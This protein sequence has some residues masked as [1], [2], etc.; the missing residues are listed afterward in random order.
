[1]STLAKDTT[2]TAV[3]ATAAATVNTKEF[4]KELEWA[5]RFAEKKSTI[6][7]LYNVALRC[8]GGSL[9][10]TATDLETAGETSIPADGEFNVTVPAALALKY[11]KKISEPEIT[12]SV[13]G[14]NLVIKHGEDCGASINGLSLESFPELPTMPADMAVLSG[15]ETAL[16][17]AIMAIS[18]LDSRFTMNGALL[19][20][21]TKTGSRF[22][23]TD[24]HRLSLVGISADAAKP[25]RGVVPKFA[26][27][28]LA[29]L[30]EDT[31]LFA[32]D[33]NHVFFSNGNR[34]IL[35]RK[36]SGNFPDYERVV[37]RA[38]AACAT[39]D[40]EALRRHGDRV[41]LFAD[42]R[43]HCMLFHLADN[44]L[45]ISAEVVDMGKSR[46]SVATTWERPEWSSGFNWEFVA[47]FLNLVPKT[48][49]DLRFNL[50]PAG[51]QNRTAVVFAVEG[52]QYVLMPMRT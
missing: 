41:A 21:G 14:E 32:S 26:L 39:I 27:S 38:M 6:P 8:D 49:F 42:S 37:P 20:I 30:G 22:V 5:A 43:S 7:I 47:E 1:M 24:G 34:T 17:R 46:A 50:H 23:S 19:E 52:W 25:F 15:L 18:A 28:E 11:L 33:E 36:L 45:T 35:S 51:E 4:T 12:L 9:R 10:L 48:A 13:N 29:R 16:P 40:A 3:R 31:A 2:I 44:K